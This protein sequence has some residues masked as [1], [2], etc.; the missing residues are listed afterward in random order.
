M[1]PGPLRLRPTPHPALRRRAGAAGR[2]LPGGPEPPG[3]HR[4]RR[5]VGGRRHPHPACG[6]R[7][8][9]TRRTAPL[10][11][12]DGTLVEIRAVLDVPPD[13]DAAVDRL[14]AIK[15]AVHAVPNAHALVGGPTATGLDKAAAQAHDRRTVIP[16]VVGVVFLIL[17]L[18]LRVLVAPLL[19]MATVLLSYLAALG[20]SWQLFRQVL[21]FPA[22]DVQIMLVGFLFL[23]ALGADYNIFLIHRIREEARTHAHESAVLSG[24]TATGGVITGAGAVLAATFAALTGAPQVAFIQ[25]GALVALGVLIDTFLVRS[26]LVPALALDTGRAFWW[27]T[28]RRPKTADPRED[29]V[30]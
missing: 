17:V 28:R 7:H 27:P 19:L 26:I 4:R 16:L 5:R 2:A 6:P 14:S 12:T 1:T 10:R 9:H 18:L 13:S 11:S 25:I 20:L 8:R 23:V 3:P 24:L 29:P 30:A 15:A 21:D 22:M